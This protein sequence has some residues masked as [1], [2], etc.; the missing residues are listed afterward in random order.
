MAN[1]HK[2]CEVLLRMKVVSSGEEE[3]RIEVES[4][5]EE[6]VNGELPLL[7]WKVTKMFRLVIDRGVIILR[8]LPL[9]QT[10]FTFR[11]ELGLGQVVE[12]K[13]E[14]KPS[15]RQSSNMPSKRAR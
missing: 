3:I 7:P 11:A 14:E 8:Q 6:E 5:R 1:T 12:E 15:E 2:C 9:G 13:A 10:G 4:I